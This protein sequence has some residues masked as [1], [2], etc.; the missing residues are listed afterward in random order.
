MVRGDGSRGPPD[1]NLFLGIFDSKNGLQVDD[2]VIYLCCS[3]TRT[4][5]VVKGRVYGA[6]EKV[7][8]R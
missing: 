7:A 3:A 6:P 2:C 1:E 5:S 8:E 4:D